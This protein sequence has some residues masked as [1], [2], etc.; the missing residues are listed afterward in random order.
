MNPR[1]K[2][3]WLLTVINRSFMKV[4]QAIKDET[5][6]VAIGE[7]IGLVI[8]FVVWFIVKL[9]T[10][11]TVPFDYKVVLGGLVGGVIAVLNFFLLGLSVQKVTSIDNQ[12]DGK[13]YFKGTYRK[14][15]LIMIVWGVL[16]FAL[17]C[18]NGIAGVLPLLFP[19]FVIRA[20]GVKDALKGAFGK[21]H[22]RR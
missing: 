21:N 19:T 16:A 3:L 4:Q 5:I 13:Q 2:R 17:P 14:R 11:G 9:M 1:R 22:E 6:K 18:F 12:D 8:M 7:G 15:M 10:Q 20:V